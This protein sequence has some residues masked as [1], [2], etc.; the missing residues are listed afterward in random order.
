MPCPRHIE[1]PEAGAS[2]IELMFATFASVVLVVAVMT[3]VTQ[4][5]NHR[6]SLTETSLATAAILNNLERAR[7]LSEAEILALDGVGFDIPGTTGSTGGLDPVDGDA[8]GLPGQLTV[9]VDQTSG[10]A[11]LYRI[12]AS[13]VWTGVNGDRRITLQSLIGERR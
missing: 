9:V 3:A 6:K 10:S 7:T 12:S 13:V 11:T 1:N 2:L 8:D 4:Q 5:S